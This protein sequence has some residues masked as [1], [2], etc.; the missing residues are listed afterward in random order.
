[1]IKIPVSEV[2]DSSATFSYVVSKF[3]YQEAMRDCKTKIEY[4]DILSFKIKDWDVEKMKNS[5]EEICQIYG[6][7]SWR[8]GKGVEK[9][10][11]YKGFSLVYNPDLKDKTV[12]INAS[13]FGSYDINPEDMPHGLSEGYHYKNTYLDSHGFWKPTPASE[14]GYL[15]E[16]LKRSKAQR[17]RSRVGIIHGELYQEENSKDGWH[18]DE[19]IFQNLRINIPITTNEHMWF[20]FEHKKPV[21]LDIGWAYSFDSFVPHRVYTTQ[22]SPA[23]RIHLVLGYSPWFNYD[24]QE[25]AWY[26][27]EF[28]GKKHP[29][30]MLVDGDIFEGLEFDPDKEFLTGKI[31][32]KDRWIR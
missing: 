14:H 31:S 2:P 10:V 32:F 23:Q 26:P 1:M 29:F 4:K 13:T 15:G 6:E 8:P 17:V 25:A 21:H 16:F 3:N 19:R 27:N 20:Q 28:F 11:I 9:N 12:D 22:N 7:F 5:I 18:I 24:E 30:D